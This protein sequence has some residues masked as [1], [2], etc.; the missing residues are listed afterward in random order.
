MAVRHVLAMLAAAAVGP[1]GVLAKSL[2][3]SDRPESAP[4]HT[5]EVELALST[6]PRSLLSQR[7]LQDDEE[8]SF[9]EAAPKNTTQKKK[10]KRKKFGK[11]LRKAAKKVKKAAKKVK[12]VAKKVK[13]VVKDVDWKKLGQKVVKGVKVVVN[14]PVVKGLI[15]TAA[16]AVGAG[17][18]AAAGITAASKI[19]GK[20]DQAKSVVD[21][22]RR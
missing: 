15:V 6:P 14:N 17:A 18:I 13:K 10:K 1:P 2:V 22:V 11:W 21:E 19:M 3:R 20:V 8:S 7:S 12:K 5:H 16:S 4:R 9:E